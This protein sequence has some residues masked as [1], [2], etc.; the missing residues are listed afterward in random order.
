MTLFERA[1]AITGNPDVAFDIGFESILH[2]EFS[3]WQKIFLKIFSSP[4]SVLRR[5]NQLNTKLNSTKIVELIYD[6]PG[7]RRDPLAL[8]R[9]R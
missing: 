8:A 7:P 1:R 2:R 3:Y 6:A 5:M 4:R 9:G